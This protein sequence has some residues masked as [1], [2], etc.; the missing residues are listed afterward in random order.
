MSKTMQATLEQHIQLI[1]AC[2]QE[3]GTLTIKALVSGTGLSLREVWSAVQEMGRTRRIHS[4]VGGWSAEPPVMPLS[5]RQ[6]HDSVLSAL[7]ASTPRH[8]TE[9]G[10]ITHL[11]FNRAKVA[12]YEMQELGLVQKIP[13]RGWVPR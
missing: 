13:L 2:L 9:I 4:V 1:E 5:G 6:L 11:S 12:L 10:K 7:S 3:N 8:V